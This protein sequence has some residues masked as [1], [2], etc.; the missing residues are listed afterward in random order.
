MTIRA[1]LTAQK[2]KADAWAYGA[3]AVAITSGLL[4]SVTTMWLAALTLAAM[5]VVVLASYWRLDHITCPRCRARLGFVIS[6]RVWPFAAP[7]I[8]FCP[9]CGISFDA[10][11]DAT[12]PPNH[13]MQL[14]AGR[15]VTN[16]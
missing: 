8:E 13:A 11:V 16:F 1:K 9:H 6:Y 10:E 12:Q 4:A 14:T 15:S 3:V 5:L 7:D 2:R